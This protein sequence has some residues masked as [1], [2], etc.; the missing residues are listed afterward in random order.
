V[1]KMAR[2]QREGLLVCALP[3]ASASDAAAA[4]AFLLLL[5]RRRSLFC[6][7]LSSVESFEIGLALAAAADVS[8]HAV[9]RPSEL[10]HI[11]ERQR[12]AINALPPPCHPTV[13]VASLT[14]ALP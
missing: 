14:L 12:D 8:G 6:I 1:K 2:L 10:K 4:A 11:P 3:V 5:L 13:T 7:S 9:E